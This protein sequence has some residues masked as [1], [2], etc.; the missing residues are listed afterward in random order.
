MENK[1]SK[2]N[3]RENNPSQQSGN[4]SQGNPGQK[5]PGRESGGDQRTFRCADAG[6]PDCRWEVS[7]RSEEELMP[8]IEQHGREKHGLS[9]L[10]DNTRNKV[11]EAIRTRA[12]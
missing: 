12:A 8:K 3:N 1:Q 5:M 10:D 9:Q 7:G 6:F 11:R 2:G 4:I